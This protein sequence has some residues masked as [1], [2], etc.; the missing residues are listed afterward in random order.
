MPI[1]IFNFF[2]TDLFTNKS[3][4]FIKSI[5][6]LCCCSLRDCI[7][8]KS[9]LAKQG[10]SL[11]C[12]SLSCE[13]QIF[14]HALFTTFSDCTETAISCLTRTLSLSRI[15]FVFEVK[16]IEGSS[17]ILLTTSHDVLKVLI[18]RLKTELF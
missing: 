2:V 7:H 11:I 1:K 6:F 5:F 16:A 13:T 18:Y 10:V 14:F 3:K 4:I 15:S 17:K 12:G 9:S 8:S